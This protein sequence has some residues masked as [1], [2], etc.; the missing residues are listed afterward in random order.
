VY[1]D[2]RKTLTLPYNVMP[3]DSMA[4]LGRQA[5]GFNQNGL[6]LN[7]P[8]YYHVDPGSVGTIFLRDG[9]EGT[10]DGSGPVDASGTR[11]GWALDLQ[12]TY[13]VGL[14]GSGQFLLTGL[15]RSDWGAQWDH[16][17]RLDS[18]THSFFIVDSPDHRNLYASS[19]LTRQ[20][21]GFSLDTTASGSRN[22]NLNGYESSSTG[23]NTALDS[24]PHSLGHSGVNMVSSLAWQLGQYTQALPGSSKQT[25]PISTQTLSMRLFTPP[26]HPDTKTNI[27]DAV[28]MGESWGS[29]RTSPT[30]LVS[31]GVNRDTPLNGKL[32]LN[33]SWRYDPLYSQLGVD[34]N[35]TLPGTI[36]SPSEQRLSLNFS[37]H[38][39]GRLL[40]NFNG[41]YGL[42]LNDANMYS[43]LTYRL[44]PNWG[45]GV[46]EFFDRYL[47]NSYQEMEFS[48]SRRVLSRDLTLTYSTLTHHITFNF[49]GTSF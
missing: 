14:N 25:T 30:M 40:F 22:P 35:G 10:G 27:N 16:T 44:D 43:S 2:G 7:V 46:G 15:T 34:P 9:V 38:P 36:Y 18:S 45:L 37:A 31:L 24:D 12:H 28:T 32:S 23:L 8:F 1:A 21:T 33:Y 3:I 11:P 47:G 17:Q 5:V 42:P 26:L 13:Q 19:D 20:F 4:P 6:T 39:I 48:L 49:L 41:G 29:G